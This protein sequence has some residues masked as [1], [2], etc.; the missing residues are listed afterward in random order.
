KIEAGEF[1][2]AGQ[3]KPFTESDSPAEAGLSELR[4]VEDGLLNALPRRRGG[5]RYRDCVG[6]AELQ[7]G[8][9]GQFDRFSVRDSSFG[10]A[11]TRTGAGANGCAFTSTGQAADERAQGSAS[12][13]GAGR[14]LTSCTAFFLPLRGGDVVRFAADHYTRQLKRKVRVA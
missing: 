4:N 6:R 3:R 5:R 13:D 1:Y 2:G 8:F 14:A 11:C 9:R 7:A 12:G 10:C